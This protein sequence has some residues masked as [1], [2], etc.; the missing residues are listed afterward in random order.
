M[1]TLEEALELRRQKDEERLHRKRERQRLNNANRCRSMPTDEYRVVLKAQGGVC[2]ACGTDDP[3]AT[4]TMFCRDHNHETGAFRALLCWNCNIA[5]GHAG[6]S[7]ERL[8]QLIE[9]LK[10]HQ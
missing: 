4:R 10:K 2:A 7:I 1:M 8:E 5:L 3:G 6:D 9:Y